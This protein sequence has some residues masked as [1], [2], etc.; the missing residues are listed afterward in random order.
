[1]ETKQGNA[2]KRQDNDKRH[3]LPLLFPSPTTL[4][5][6]PLVPRLILSVLEYDNAEEVKSLSFAHGDKLREN[7]TR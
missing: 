1:M 6:N 7:E 4:D 5:S 3:R 2:I